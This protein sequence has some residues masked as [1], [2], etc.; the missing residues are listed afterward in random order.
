MCRP[1]TSSMLCANA[2]A[3]S[4]SV[5]NTMYA[6]MWSWVSFRSCLMI[7]E[8]RVPFASSFVLT[9]TE[10]KRVDSTVP[11]F[12][13]SVFNAL[14]LTFPERFPTKIVRCCFS[15]S[16]RALSFDFLAS[17]TLLS[18]SSLNLAFFFL[19]FGASTASSGSIRT[20][21]CSCR[22]RFSDVVLS[23]FLL[24]VS[25]SLSCRGRFSVVVSSVSSV[26]SVFLI[27]FSFSLFFTFSS[28]TFS[29]FSIGFSL[30]FFF[31]FFSFFPV[32]GAESVFPVF[33]AESV[34]GCGKAS[35]L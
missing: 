33:G 3:A 16:S 30:S 28:F 6:F 32:S 7:L 5:L 10:R 34:A 20:V 23:V 24:F 13:K 21:S 14:S 4:A 17:I 15:R 18:S 9:G 31:S 22:G 1:S 35:F 27:F 2:A 19:V 12:E 26:L 11:Y 25:I 29:S 8:R